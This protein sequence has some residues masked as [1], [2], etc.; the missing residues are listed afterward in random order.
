[1]EEYFNEW[2]EIKKLTN[3]NE[4]KLGIKAREVFWIKLG[5]NIGSEEYGK[6]GDFYETCNYYKKINT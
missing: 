3:Q 5:Q 1:M 6:G 2:N 4:R